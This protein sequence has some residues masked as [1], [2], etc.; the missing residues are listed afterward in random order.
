LNI[1]TCIPTYN[2]EHKIGELIRASLRY[3]D[4]VVVC[5]D[6]SSD[7]TVHEAESA[8]AYVIKH[9]TNKGKGA[10]LKSLFKYVLHTNSDIVVTMDGDGQFLPEEIEKLTKPIMDG[11]S[12]IIIGYRFENNEE[13]PHY[14]KIGNKFLDK[15]SNSASEL[16]FRDTQSGFRAY[17]INAI[18][19]IQFTNDGFAADS[20]I[21]INAS[22]KDLKISEVKITVIYDT[23]G[24]TSTKNPI[25][26]GGGVLLSLIEIILI[27]RPLTFLGMPGL[28]ILIAGIFSSINVITVFNETRYFSIPFTLIS[29]SFLILGALL[30]SI[31]SILFSFNK[32]IKKT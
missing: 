26:H 23:G 7:N 1:I 24:K 22:K 32:S 5:D 20:E 2:E 12:D 9:F 25:S 27:N 11:Q 21:L 19:N 17:S 28:I 3:C 14:R 10:A 6:G 4:S 29:M 8:G 16:P 31:A 18:K 13:I 30:L 15:I